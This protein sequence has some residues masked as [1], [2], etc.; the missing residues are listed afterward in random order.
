MNGEE[1]SYIFTIISTVLW[2]FVFIP[3]LYKNYK[4]KNVK[5]LSLYLIFGLLFGD[6]FSLISSISKNLTPIIAYS[7][8]FHIFID[9][10]LII[11]ILYYRK[12][13]QY[14]LLDENIYYSFYMFYE[15]CTTLLSFSI[16]TIFVSILIF[17]TNE[18]CSLLLS[19]IIAWISTFIFMISR[20]PQIILNFQLKSTKG[21]SLISLILIN[22]A[23][24]FF[25]SSILIILIDIPFNQHYEYIM[26][27]IQWIVSVVFTFFLDCIIFYQF[28]IFKRKN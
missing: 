8:I 9:L 6:C 26:N 18:Y 25:C 19:N 21:L 23:N 12:E 11:Q 14:I 15:E 16:C 20:I 17:T 13:S 28:Y 2:L 27:N 7:S 22:V 1:L 24:F 3:Q 10:L 5:Y 4:N